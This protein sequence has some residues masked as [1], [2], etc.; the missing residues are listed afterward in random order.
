VLVGVVI[1]RILRNP[2]ATCHVHL[3]PRIEIRKSHFS[4][5]VREHSRGQCLSELHVNNIACM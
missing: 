3:D 2:E 1:S 5:A 4:C